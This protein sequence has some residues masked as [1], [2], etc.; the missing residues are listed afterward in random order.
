[1]SLAR[2]MNSARKAGTFVSLGALTLLAS[3]IGPPITITATPLPTAIEG[4][5]Y[6]QILRADTS[7]RWEV[8]AGSLPSGMRLSSDGV[9]SGTP[10][11]AGSFAFTVRAT[12]TSGLSSRT[13]EESF[14]LEVTPRLVLAVNLAIPQV[15]V[16]YSDAITASGGT[17]PYEFSSIGLTAG[18]ELNATTGGITGTPVTPTNG[19]P[20]RFQVTDSGDP[21]QT[22]TVQ[23]TLEINPAPIVFVTT[24]LPNGTVGSGYLETIEIDQGQGPFTFT[25]TAGVLP[26]G[27][28]LTRASGAISGTPT[29]A[30]TF[31]FTI[32]VVDSETPPNEISRE[33]TITVE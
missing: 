12:Q 6:S 30:G 22:D 16:V 27:L 4:T 7:A 5:S 32:E 3:C 17:P 15:G 29:A 9:L 14:T 18:L 1:M 24:E 23:I 28:E 25:V 21:Q 10:A 26:D 19:V 8:V 13:G 2:K 20:V 31:T 33:F 11:E